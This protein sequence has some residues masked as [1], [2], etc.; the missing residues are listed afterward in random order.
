MRTSLLLILLFALPSQ[1]AGPYYVDPVD[2]NDAND[3]L[4][5]GEAWATIQSAITQSGAGETVYLMDGAV[6]G[7]ETIDTNNAAH[8]SWDNKLTI[9]KNPGDDAIVRDIEFKDNSFY[10]ELNDIKVRPLAAGSG[11]L[12]TSASSMRFIGLNYTGVWNTNFSDLIE[13][14]PSGY[15]ALSDG[16]YI[17]GGGAEA[18]SLMDD[19]TIEDCNITQV[20]QGITIACFVGDANGQWTIRNNHVHTTARSQIKVDAGNKGSNGHVLVDGNHIHDYY[21]FF[22]GVDMSHASGVTMKATNMTVQNNRIHATGSTSGIATYQNNGGPTGFHTILIQNNLVYDNDSQYAI[23]LLDISDTGSFIFRNNTV[24]GW[25][26]ASGGQIGSGATHYFTVMQVRPHGWYEAD[27]IPPADCSGLEI[28]NNTIVGQAYFDG[29]QGVGNTGGLVNM[30]EDYNYFYAV[31]TPFNQRIP[32]HDNTVILTSTAN[33]PFDDT[34]EDG[35]FVGGNF[36]TQLHREELDDEYKL[37]LGSPAINN[38]DAL[39]APATDLEG[40]ARVGDP[41]IGCYEFG[42][43]APVE[44]GVPTTRYLIGY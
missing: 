11:I 15:D 19:I 18:D 14:D 44:P 21:S 36:T 22:T 42:G 9:T 33:A 34:F 1:A 24:V 26:Q 13:R 3:G 12:V 37:V 28:Y 8:N 27:G 41:D 23:R 7:P 38:G 31:I 40:N 35:Y 16:F 5:E 29:E 10:V 17:T 4:S 2:G 39:N 32:S 30:K 25:N 6:H 43:E 20:I